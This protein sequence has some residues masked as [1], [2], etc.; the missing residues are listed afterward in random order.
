[1]SGQKQE[2]VHLVDDEALL[3]TCKPEEMVHGNSGENTTPKR[4]VREGYV[5]TRRKDIKGDLR[6]LMLADGENGAD[7]VQN[8]LRRESIV[9]IAEAVDTLEDFI[10]ALQAS[11][12]DLIVAVCSMPS[13]TGLAAL[14]A[15]RERSS[16]VPFI[17]VTDPV[18]DEVAV[19]LIRRGATDHIL[20]TR[21]GRLSTAVER[22]I[23][24]REERTERARAGKEQKRLA[25]AV[26]NIVEGIAIISPELTFEYA[27]PSL[28]K[29]TGY[30]SEELLG[31]SVGVLWISGYDARC[32]A[33][34]KHVAAGN[35]W[36]GCLSHK[37]KDGTEAVHGATISPLS[38]HSGAL[39]GYVAVCRDPSDEDQLERQR[40]HAEK[41]D[42]LRTLCGGIA[43][44]FNNILAIILGFTEL[45]AGCT[46][47]GSRD[48]GYLKRV[49]EAG[50]RGRDLI[51]QLLA[52]SRTTVQ[53]KEPLL[54]S[55]V[56]KETVRLLR[57]TVPAGIRIRVR[58]VSESHLI[59][60][61]PAQIR[62]ILL[63]L[64]GN[65]IH[66]MR[67]KGGVLNMELFDFNVLPS[68]DGNQGMKPGS[69]MKLKVRDAVIGMEPAIFDRIFDPFFTTRKTGEGTGL[70]LFVVHGIVTQSNGYV[71]VESEPGRGSAFTVYLPVV[72]NDTR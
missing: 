30:A 19:E 53:Q 44:N 71:T 25:E 60:G 33:V 13:L 37:R 63:N 59:P 48:E 1:M 66:A 69:Y 65:A 50:F 10:K 64:S 21:L 29:M 38:D 14:A 55:A 24:E 35:A 3:P 62:Q 27:N 6:I 4:S 2:A 57:A 20:K 58:V 51:R 34:W 68:Q 12:P 67:G 40:R 31:K 32:A 28:C 9:F 36:T 23:S 43:H 18:G 8:V 5:K 42:A 41:M 45:V 22:A 54:L 7:A 52:F 11:L 17:F 49:V 72:N 39:T 70:G 47:K 16:D 15:A 26:E 56:V 61:D 46:T